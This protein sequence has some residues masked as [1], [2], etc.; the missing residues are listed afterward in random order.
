MTPTKNWITLQIT[1]LLRRFRLAL[2]NAFVMTMHRVASVLTV[3]F[4]ASICQGAT[5]IML[6]EVDS[7]TNE[8]TVNNCSCSAEFPC[9]RV[10]RR[11]SSCEEVNASAIADVASANESVTWWYDDPLVICCE[12]ALADSAK[13]TL[14]HLLNFAHVT[15]L[16]LRQC[17]NLA[18]A[19]ASDVI[20]VYGL[21][22]IRLQADPSSS[23][24][25]D[26]WFDLNDG[27]DHT[28]TSSAYRDYHIAFLSGSL[29]DDSLPMKSWSY[30]ASIL[31]DN[32]TDTVATAL[33]RSPETIKSKL[34]GTYMFTPIYG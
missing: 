15:S 25:P 26:K 17:H 4:C 8:T 21:T 3:V 11:C 28:D 23:H 9:G 18:S 32:M 20:T 29:I 16:K 34:D 2:V 22:E 6:F 14:E 24:Y 10:L 31:D 1:Y 5:T 7:T 13:T 27:S 19:A 12:S 33:A 30:V